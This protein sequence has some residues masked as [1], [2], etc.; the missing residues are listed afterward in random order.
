MSKWILPSSAACSNK[1]YALS[2]TLLNTM[3]T[4]SVSSSWVLRHLP[5]TEALNLPSR[6]LSSPLRNSPKLTH[7][8]LS[9]VMYT[10]LSL[11]PCCENMPRKNRKISGFHYC[12]SQRYSFLDTVMQVTHVPQLGSFCLSES[13]SGSDAFALQTR[14]KKDGDNYIINGSKMWITNSY[15]AEIF[16]V[17]ANV[18]IFNNLYDANSL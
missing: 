11:T 4:V 17:F 3:L 7:R 13:A 8:S 18:R 5:N 2:Q 9:C 1:E 14:A 16:L 6:Q 15:E 12:P 10:I